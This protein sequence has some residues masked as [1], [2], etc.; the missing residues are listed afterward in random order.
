MNGPSFLHTEP[1]TADATAG[2]T[3]LTSGLYLP[4]HRVG[5]D[6]QSVTPKAETIKET[7]T[8]YGHFTRNRF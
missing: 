5:M 1:V 8:K 7:R 2:V 4:N 6:S 3:A